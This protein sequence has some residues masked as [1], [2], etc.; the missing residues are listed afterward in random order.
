MQLI[1]PARSFVRR[2]DVQIKHTHA[3]E[4]NGPYYAYSLTMLVAVAAWSVQHCL[5]LLSHSTHLSI[6]RACTYRERARQRG[7][8]DLR[9]SPRN[10][11]HVTL[12]WRIC[13]CQH[14][15]KLAIDYS[16]YCDSV[17][18]LTLCFV[19][20]HA[21]F[22]SAGTIPAGTAELKIMLDQT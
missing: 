9:D 7:R 13:S 11:L 8:L 20:P 3:T 1:K 12:M 4:S 22:S 21:S 16:I 15:K 19:W 14:A 10:S 18:N 6:E 2:P 17:S 5:I